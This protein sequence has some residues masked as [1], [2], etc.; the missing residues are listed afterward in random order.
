MVIALDFGGVLP[1]TKHVW[2]LAAVTAC[3]ASM[4]ARGLSF[5]CPGEI[6][7]L[8]KAFAVSGLLAI[9][10]LYAALQTVPLPPSVVSWWSPASHSAYFEWA[11]KLIRLDSGDWIPVSIAAFDSRHAIAFL[12]LCL[13]LSCFS[14]FVFH[15][16]SRITFL[17]SVLT[18]GACSVAVIGIARKLMPDF[19]LWS[20]RSGGEG[21]PFGTFLNR[22]NAA[23]AINL[24]IASALGVILWRRSVLMVSPNSRTGR[25][26]SDWL[27]DPVVL[28]AL[29][30]VTICL[31]GLIACG[32]RGGL[33]SG[34]VAG[35]AT[36]YSIRN[37]VRREMGRL[38][39]VLMGTV[40]VA[41]LVFLALR[42]GTSGNPA[43]QGDT[44]QQ[45]GSTV[46]AGG[47]RLSTDTRLAHW[48]DGFRT[49]IKH[50]PGGS[51]LSSYGFA[52]LP[53]QETS[54]WRRCEHADNLW[55]EM[56]VELG[57]VGLILALATMFLLW[58]SLGRLKLSADAID[59]ALYAAGVYLTV[60]I[61]ISQFLDFGLIVPANA[62]AVTLLVSTLVARASAAVVTSD[63]RLSPSSNEKGKKKLVLLRQSDVWWKSSLTLRERLPQCLCGIGLLGLAVLALDRLA[64][65]S[66]V[67]NVVRLSDVNLKRNL[68]DENELKA[69]VDESSHLLGRHAHPELLNV[70]ARIEFQRGRLLELKNLN[71]GRLPEHRQ[72]EQ[73]VATSRMNRRLGWR[74]SEPTLTDRVSNR[75]R[76][77]KPLPVD[78]DLL[79]EDSPYSNAVR[80]TQLSLRSRPLALQPRTD[81]VS[82][83][84]VHQSPQRTQTAIRQ[85]AGLFKNTPELQLSFGT[86]AAQHGDYVMAVEA[87]ERAVESGEKMKNRVLGRAARYQGFPLESLTTDPS[88]S[89][90]Q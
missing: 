14:V 23:L 70:V 66:H 84:F 52:Y 58:R 79:E 68:L 10:T 32:S 24:G 87:W 7:L 19:D 39:G 82:L 30:A 49:A 28:S 18:I 38:G 50:M 35:I 61:A 37:T 69:F 43:L 5:G 3:A 44:L 31:V 2:A 86:M 33:L 83:E 41:F 20:F 29:A 17:L 73:Y 15:D 1:W 74:A 89:R 75:G 9:L 34:T 48:P 11:G 51:G 56:L 42:A 6:R 55:L 57:V 63:A 76:S 53:W 4:V 22:N 77:V 72:L 26:E 46:E 62:I 81:L 27:R 67:D 21:A 25:A 54:P 40:V 36:L 64:I 45:I 80:L 85:A 12:F 60:M 59:Q 13:V 65:D 8:P 78:Q 47:E 90:T 71:V 88:D 16:R